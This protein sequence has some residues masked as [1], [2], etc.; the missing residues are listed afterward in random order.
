MNRLRDASRLMDAMARKIRRE[1]F[2]L[3]DLD[4]MWMELRLDHC[5]KLVRESLSKP[6]ILRE[7]AESAIDNSTRSFYLRR[8][9]NH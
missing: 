4:L 7:K 1:Q 2:Q 9:L 8:P 5:K 3:G 6:D